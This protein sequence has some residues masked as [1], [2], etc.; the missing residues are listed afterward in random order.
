M[1][2]S[3]IAYLDRNCL[4]IMKYKQHICIIYMIPPEIKKFCRMTIND[5][6]H[7]QYVIE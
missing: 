2:V 1:I 3:I 5:R 7:E 6:T 4:Y